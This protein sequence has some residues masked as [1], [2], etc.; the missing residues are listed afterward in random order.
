MGQHRQRGS[1]HGFPKSAHVVRDYAT[2]KDIAKKFAGGEIKLLILLGGPGKGKGQIVKRAMLAKAS[3][4]NEQFF[5]ALSQSVANILAS[6]NPDAPRQPDPP[7]LGPGL[8]LK[9]HVSP[10][11]FHIE[12]YRH[13]DAPI[14]IDDADSFFAD[15]QL[16]ERTKH[17][18]ET[19]RYKLL[20]HEISHA[21]TAGGHG[22]IWQRRMAWSE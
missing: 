22:M 2:L 13:R 6:L 18:T 4:T 1:K 8:Y 3:A 19:D 9:G 14:C 16:R 17:L 5:Q 12:A 15:A 11:S 20:I 21:V 7:N 10:I